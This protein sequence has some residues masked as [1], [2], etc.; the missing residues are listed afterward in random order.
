[1][2]LPNLITLARFLAV[3][4]VV[5]A[6]ATGEAELAFWIFVAAGVS[7]AAD[8]FIAKRFGLQT[9][10]GAHLDPLADK[11]LL[12]CI[13]V[14]LA[15]GGQVPAWLA[16]AVV[17]RDALILGGVGVA[18]AMGRRLTIRPLVIS[19]LNTAAQIGFAALMLADAAFGLAPGRAVEVGVVL[20][21]GLTAL[22]AL[23]YLFD[24]ARRIVGD[25]QRVDEGLSPA[26]TQDDGE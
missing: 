13:Y 8:G 2:N 3:P 9:E 1:M 17:A 23:A 5:W 7:D 12:V 22:S 25:G 11:A 26:R 10:L 18:Y 21:A 4:A 14:A 15:L 20:V 16:A 24:W 19:K 6:I